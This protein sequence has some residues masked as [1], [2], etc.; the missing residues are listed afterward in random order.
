M[1]RHL[2]AELD[3]IVNPMPIN[4]GLFRMIEEE[5]ADGWVEVKSPEISQYYD[6]DGLDWIITKL[7][8]AGE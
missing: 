3:E 4:H 2:E 7:H 1:V 5:E 8:G 6:D